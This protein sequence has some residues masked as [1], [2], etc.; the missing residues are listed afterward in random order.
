MS[1]PFAPTALSPMG[2]RPVLY[3]S[4]V[5][6]LVLLVAGGEALVRG[7]VALA[8]RLGVSPLLIGLT[9]VGFGTSTP[10]LVTSLQAAFT[11][12]PGIAVGNVVGSNIANILLILG[13]GALLMPLAVERRAFLRDGTVLVAS[14]LATLAI[15]LTGALSRPAG[16]MLV[17]GLAG[18]LVWAYRSERAAPDSADHGAAEVSAMPL[19]VAL[20]YALGGIAVTVLGARFLVS[21][22]S[23]LATSL[24]VSDAVIGL[25]VVAVGTS[26]PELVTA[27]VAS[28]RRQPDV[29]FGNVVGS[30][31]YNVLGILGITALVRPIPV[32]DQIAGFDIWVMLGAT[33]ALLVVA[34]SGWRI[35]RGEGAALLIGY[36]AYVTWL[37][38]G[39]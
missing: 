20:A 31:I 22:A 35:T 36:G 38:V 25:T 10:E 15:V 28:I 4:I 23:D 29:A 11:G 24:G 18:Y 32:P 30:N 8:S 26:L 12:S 3:L 1:E 16:L 37:A 21:G 9:V 7:A 17:L 13:I 2:F 6:G 39:A 34:I 19:P 5:F 14:A 27:V 33:G